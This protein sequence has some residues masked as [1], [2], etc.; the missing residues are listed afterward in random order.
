MRLKSPCQGIDFVTTD[1]YGNRFQLSD[2]LGKRIMLSFFRNAACPFCNF[3]V[4]ELTHQYKAWRAKG[5]EV[6]AV[7]SSPADEVRHWV[8]RHPRP[9]HVL[10]DPGLKLYNLYGIEHSGS[11]LL[12]ALLFNFPRVARGFALGPGKPRKNPHPTIVPADFLMQEDGRIVETWYARNT[13][14]HIPLKRVE[15]FI[16][17]RRGANPLTAA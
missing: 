2:H 9:F 11:A 15:R 7:F 8:A 12:K 16:N 3:R 4:Y 5:L 6:V 1:V 13:S 10:S 17:A 14:D